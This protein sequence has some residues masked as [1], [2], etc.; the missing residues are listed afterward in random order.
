M[1]AIIR[2]REKKGKCARSDVR[3]TEACIVSTNVQGAGPAEGST[4]PPSA[5][6]AGFSEVP[7]M[8]RPMREMLSVSF[9]EIISRIL[10]RNMMG[11]V[12]FRIDFVL[13]DPFGSRR[14]DS[15][16][17]QLIT[18]WITQQSFSPWPDAL[19]LLKISRIVFMV[20]ISIAHES[21]IPHPRRT[22]L[23]ARSRPNR[24]S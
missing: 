10:P 14:V 2:Q 21:A 13:L 8:S 1:G 17:H 7:A 22:S 11:Q 5:G 16:L 23:R 3:I 15:Y 6:Y 4:G 19:A 9:A 12:S 20:G 18:S 24:G